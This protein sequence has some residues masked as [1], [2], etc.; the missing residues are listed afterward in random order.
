MRNVIKTDH[1]MHKDVPLLSVAFAKKLIIFL[2]LFVCLIGYGTQI[3]NNIGHLQFERNNKSSKYR[4]T[5]FISSQLVFN[6]NSV[7]SS[8]Q[9]P[10]R[11]GSSPNILCHPPHFIFLYSISYHLPNCL[12]ILLSG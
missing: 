5:Y 8:L 4:E 3:F 11:Q 6:S 12:F 7:R 2:M 9:H 1:E 10:I